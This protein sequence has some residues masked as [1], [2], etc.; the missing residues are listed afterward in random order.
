MLEPISEIETLSKALEDIRAEIKSANYELTA[1]SF[2]LI[3]QTFQLV[4]SSPRL[5]GA[6]QRLCPEYPHEEMLANVD[7]AGAPLPTSQDLLDRYHQAVVEHPLISQWMRIGTIPGSGAPTLLTARW[8]C[9]LVSIRHGTAHLVLLVR[10][11]PFQYLVQIRS[12]AKSASPGCYD[13]PVAGHVD[14][15]QSYAETLRK[16]SREELDLDIDELQELRSLEG[17]MEVSDEP[18][19]YFYNVEF[20]QVYAGVLPADLILK[21]KP[22]PGEVA[23]VAL[24]PFHELDAMRRAIP[25]VF[26]PSIQGTLD[27]YSEILNSWS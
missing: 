25:S 11:D 27:R 26:A 10:G 3:L 21:L 2:A 6:I 13:L 18:Q 12:M 24:F 14:G 5:A 17:Y 7:P 1:A 9:H 19:N 23:A 8:L 16:E 20:H 22:L 4:Q 15:L